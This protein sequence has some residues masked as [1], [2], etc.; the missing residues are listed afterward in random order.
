[1]SPARYSLAK[2]ATFWWR[3]DHDSAKTGR[4]G[5][6]PEPREPGRAGGGDEDMARNDRRACRR[7]T[8]G[9]SRLAHTA[10]SFH[11]NNTRLGST[12]SPCG[13]FFA[14]GRGGATGDPDAA[15]RSASVPGQ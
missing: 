12:A 4:T 13:F 9:P 10:S 1:M 11:E 6:S 7:G 2:Y 5:N 15:L 8:M 3:K 14:N